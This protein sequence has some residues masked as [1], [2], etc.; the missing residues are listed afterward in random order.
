VAFPTTYLNDNEEIVLDL[1]PHWWYL[2]SSAA[3][4]GLFILLVV[5]IVAAGWPS[6]I[7][8][9]I[10]IGL[11]VALV[12]F[13]SK[14][15]QW[16]ST[17][18]VVTTDRVIYRSGVLSKRGIEIPLDRINT[19][20]F[21]QRLIERLLGQG[22][23]RIE[24]ASEQ[25]QQT[26][27]NVRHPNAVQQEIYRAKENEEQ[28]RIQQFGQA[29]QGPATAAAPPSEPTIPEKIDQL[30]ELRAKGAITDEEYQQKKRDLLDRM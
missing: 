16:V 6:A 24:S 27:S 13:V 30:N 7:G 23:L 21:R 8:W 4:F 17:N 29:A 5:I 28:R 9:V 2:A 12:W 25:G 26:F 15:M 19:V 22:D 14:Y 1:R 20:H 11:V 10:G 18:F 3:V